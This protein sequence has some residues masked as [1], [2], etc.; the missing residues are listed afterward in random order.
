[1]AIDPDWRTLRRWWLD[2]AER[3]FTSASF[4]LDREGAVRWIHP[5][6]TLAV[7]DADWKR[8]I[9]TLEGIL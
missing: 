8:L 3:G 1:V 4:L 6:G 2:G 9:A 5:G 7:D